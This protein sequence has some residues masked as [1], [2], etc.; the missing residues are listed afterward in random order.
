MYVCMYVCT[1]VYMCV[2]I[3][4]QMPPCTFPAC[5][6]KKLTAFQQ[7]LVIKSMRVVL[8]HVWAR[9][10]SEPSVIRREL[11]ELRGSECCMDP[12]LEAV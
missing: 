6:D 2:W 9:Q 7:A 11:L 10:G 3:C 5:R 12:R 8:I 4:M 1:C